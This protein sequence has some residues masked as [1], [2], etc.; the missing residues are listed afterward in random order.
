[1]GGRYPSPIANSYNED[2]TMADSEVFSSVLSFQERLNHPSTLSLVNDVNLKNEKATTRS[3]FDTSAVSQS[4][5]VR[6]TRVF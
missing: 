6:V 4:K 2:N 3:I 5:N 1:M